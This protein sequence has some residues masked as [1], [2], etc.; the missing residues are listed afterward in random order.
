MLLAP[1]SL[2]VAK[3]TNFLRDLVGLAALRPRRHAG[4]L[5]NGEPT[6]A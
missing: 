6:Y 2:D 4:L 1:P 3:D 5:T